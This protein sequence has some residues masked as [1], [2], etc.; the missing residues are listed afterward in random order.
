MFAQQLYESVHSPCS[1][2]GGRLTEMSAREL[3][4]ILRKEGCVELR[5]KGSHLQ[6]KCGRCQST[7]PVH[8]GHD[9]KKGTL[10]AIERSLEVCLGD[11]FL[12][13]D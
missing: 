12:D 11:D 4:K 10:G 8:G 13:D 9:I 5:Q 3:R 7:V 2:C 6:V 1:A